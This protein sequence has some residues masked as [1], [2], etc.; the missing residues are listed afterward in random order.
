MDKFHLQRETY[1][2][3][4]HPVIKVH[5]IRHKRYPQG[6]RD[7][8]VRISDSEMLALRRGTIAR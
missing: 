5:H 2:P 4:V 8:D 7:R 3:F 1:F 6:D